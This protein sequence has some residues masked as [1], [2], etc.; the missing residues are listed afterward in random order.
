MNPRNTHLWLGAAILSLVAGLACKPGNQ[1]GASGSQTDGG[2]KPPNVVV[3]SNPQ[4]ADLGKPAG[5][6]LDR[7]PAEL[8]NDAFDYYGLGN[9]EAVPMEIRASSQPGTKPGTQTAIFTEVRDGE[10]VFVFICTGSLQALGAREFVLKKDGLYATKLGDNAIEP[11]QIE[12]ASPLTPGKTWKTSGAVT[13]PN[14]QRYVEKATYRV[15][16]LETV[17]VKSKSYEA[18]RV[19]SSG[20]L[21]LDSVPYKTRATVWFAKG[22][23]QVKAESELITKKV[24]NTVTIEATP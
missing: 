7:L 1:P 8:R 11:P 10:A 2:K 9:T 18:L 15:I 5:L 4:P 14:G 3:S 13:L 20:T 6:P 16:G 21:V 24:R 22:K 19:E 17:K 12:L 23:G